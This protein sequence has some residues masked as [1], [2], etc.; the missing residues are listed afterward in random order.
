MS[1]RPAKTIRLSETVSPYGPGAIVDILGQSFIVPT[2]DKWPPARLRGE[3]RHDRLA[4]R[5]NVQELWAAPTTADPDGKGPG[6]ELTRFPGW[7]FCQVCRRMVRW[8]K[9]METG[10]A[11]IC[12]QDTCKGRL[13][14]MR[15]VAVCVSG[16]HLQDVPWAYWTHRNAPSE[17][18]AEDRLTFRTSQGRAEGLSSLAVKCEKCG[19]R[20]S[21]GDLRRDVFAAEGIKCRGAQPWE[22]T[23]FDE[24]R[25]GKPVD[26]QQRGA[27]S[28]HFAKT[29]SAIDIPV[30]EGR[31]TVESDRIMGHV[32]FSAL[33]AAPENLREG[34]ALQIAEDVGVHVDVVLEVAGVGLDGPADRRAVNSSLQAEEFEAFLAAVAGTAPSEAFTTR[35]ETLPRG[36]GAGADAVIDRISDVVLVDRL[37]DVRANEGFT[38]YTP[39]AALVEAVPASAYEKRWLPAV[40]GYGEG[41]FLRFDPEAVRSWAAF[42]AVR[43][44][45]AAVADNQARSLLGARLHLSSPEYVL[46]HTFAHILMRELAF[47][48]GYSAASIR[49][50]IYCESDGD[51]GVF[52]YT[53]TTDVEGTLGGLVRQGEGRLLLPA[54]LA[55]LQQAVWCPNDPVCMEAEPQSIDGLNHA[56][57][58]ACCLASETS[59]ES[60]NLLLDRALIVGSAGVPG[61]FEPA[62]EAILGQRL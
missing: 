46:L 17:C 28:L 36:L 34:L 44:R 54:L 59:C 37:R 11:P 31:A 9:S 14:P 26:P 40:E 8:T 61:F 13:V 19:H 55:S 21:L 22:Y 4:A 30:V 1:E 7:L 38:R 3:V 41:I 20:R 47:T 50:R 25:C 49:E 23:P 48:S 57:C 16:S 43:Q 5:L 2:G 51:Y 45:G 33:Q 27:T 42:P 12:A 58:H 62:L 56:A 35:L 29:Y 52:V 60:Q 24:E 39:E 53:T 6:L 15:F 10:A 32:F 18:K